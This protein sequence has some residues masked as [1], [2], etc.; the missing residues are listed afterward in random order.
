MVTILNPSAVKYLWA[1]VIS[2]LMMLSSL[3]AIFS[4]H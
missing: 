3:L 2:M 4:S 1:A